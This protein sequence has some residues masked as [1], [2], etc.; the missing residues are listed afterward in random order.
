MKSAFSASLFVLALAAVSL[1]DLKDV[2]GSW[3]VHYVGGL[4]MKTIGG[5]E[6]EFE[7]GIFVAF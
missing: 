6:F 4:A 2:E 7:A 1:A 5:A 3:A